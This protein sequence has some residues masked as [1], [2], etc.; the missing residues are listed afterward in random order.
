[1]AETPKRKERWF[2]AAKRADFQKIGQRFQVSPVLAR[3]MRNRDLTTM[4]EIEQYLHG[5]LDDIPSPYLLK[6]IKKGAMII[7]DKIQSG[8]K[9]RIISDY[10]VDGVSSNYILYKG[11]ERCSALVDYCIPDRIEDG[12]GIN[13]HLIQN[14]WE[15]GVDTIITCDNGI[16]ARDQIAYGKSL[17][18]TIIVT[19]H[20]D[21]PFV[22]GENGEILEQ[23]P[24]ADA[25]ID[26]KQKQCKYP[27]ENIC[28]AVVAF[29]FIMVLYDLFEIPREEAFGFLE[30]AALATVCDVMPL[31][32]ENRILVKE[33]LKALKNTKIIGLKALI[34]VNQLEGKK[35][36]AYHFGFILGPC[37]N[38]SGR[39]ASAQ[40]ALKLLLSDQEGEA[41]ERAGRLKELN[42]ERKQM[43]KDG[44]EDAMRYIKEN[45]MEEDK[46]LVVFLPHCHES[47]A[48]IIAGRVKEEYNRPTFVLTRTKEGV[49]GSGRSIEGYHM[50]QEMSQVKE[51]FLK[52]GGHP[53]AAGLSMEEEKIPE[54][55]ARLNHNCTLTEE[56]FIPKV[57]IDIALPVGY[58]TEDFI[59]ELTLLEP[60]GTGNEKPLFAQ[61]DLQ[62]EHMAVRG[63][64][65]RCLSFLLKD[66][67]GCR[68]SAVYF[69]DANEVVSQMEDFY[70]KD[71][72]SRMKKGII[73]GAAM[74]CT[75]YPQVNEWQGQKNIQIVL[76]NLSWK[77]AE[78][79]WKRQS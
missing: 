3:L 11:L 62:I 49:K 21:V 45:Q 23:I 6:D 75:Y 71:R 76:K 56:D 65:G 61:K 63:A 67:Q 25:V 66:G 36:G 1:M 33:G 37:I 70:G 59:E 48:G 52:F 20:H 31:Q 53:M 74:D 58:I 5:S 14:A 4:E 42:E 55:R 24:E 2:I 72:V 8:K 40:D 16:A 43:T 22:T 41:L 77:M 13:E 73:T 38:A 46:V 26:P 39:L 27:W 44:I 7:K 64:Q 10:D 57:H 50:Y 29:K 28:G 47:I 19:D 12:Y 34:Q 54:L 79:S 78:E 51:L 30:I 60:F 17:G 69:G 15:S 35:I 18:M 68:I 9:I 32:G